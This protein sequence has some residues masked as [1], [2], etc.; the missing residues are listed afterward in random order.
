VF[1]YGQQVTERFTDVDTDETERQ[2]AVQV[3]GTVR[4]ASNLTEVYRRSQRT[5]PR[6]E[7]VQEWSN[8]S[9]VRHELVRV[10]GV[11]VERPDRLEEARASTDE[12]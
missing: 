5:A 6:R 7:R 3:N 8:G 10:G 12:G 11:T 2:V 4:A 9:R 1:R